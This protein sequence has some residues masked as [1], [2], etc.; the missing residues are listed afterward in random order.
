MV[1]PTLYKNI[2]YNTKYMYDINTS[3]NRQAAS[4][5]Y[6]AWRGEIFKK[7]NDEN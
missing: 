4:L 1:I 7:I 6:R 5:D 2:W 3:K